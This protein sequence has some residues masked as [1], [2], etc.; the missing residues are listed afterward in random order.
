MQGL[1]WEGIK[2]KIIKVSGLACLLAGNPKPPWTATVSLQ[3]GS[4]GKEA[5]TVPP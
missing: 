4:D 1:D 3:T 2:M 5:G